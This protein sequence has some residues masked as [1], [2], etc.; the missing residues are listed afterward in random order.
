[1]NLARL[2]TLPGFETDV[3]CYS[4]DVPYF[5]PLTTECILFGPGTIKV[6][7][8]EDEHIEIAELEKS[9]EDY[10]TIYQKLS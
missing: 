7:H 10:C 6:A 8:S 1:M 3:V 4:T 9:V 2:K 5:F